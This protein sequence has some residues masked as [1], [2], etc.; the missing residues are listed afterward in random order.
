MDYKKRFLINAFL[1]VFISYLCIHLGKVILIK[2][3][4]GVVPDFSLLKAVVLLFPLFFLFYTAVYRPKFVIFSIFLLGI[5]L[6]WYNNATA[7]SIIDS[8]SW[9]YLRYIKDALKSVPPPPFEPDVYTDP[10]YGPQMI[11]GGFLQTYLHL[12]EMVILYSFSLINFGLLLTSM[13]LFAREK[14][15]EKVG[16]Y[17]LLLSFFAWGTFESGYRSYCLT[18]IWCFFCI[19]IFSFS[20]LFFALFFYVKSLKSHSLKY[21]SG[22]VVCGFLC[23]TNH[24]V[25]GVILL[26]IVFCL[27]VEKVITTRKIHS[28]ALF[29]VFACVTLILT[30]MWPFYDLFY[31]FNRV[32]ELQ[33]LVVGVPPAYFYHPVTLLARSLGVTVVGIFFLWKKR[34]PFVVLLLGGSLLYFFLGFPFYRRFIVPIAFSLHL[35]IALFLSDY[36]HTRHTKLFPAAFVLFL[37]FFAV[38]RPGITGFKYVQGNE[39]FDVSFLD[40][41]IDEKDSKILSDTMTEYLIRTQTD[42]R[43]Q[44]TTRVLPHP[45]IDSFFRLDATKEERI[46]L[47]SENLVNYV[48]IN[49][50]RISYFQDIVESL[51]DISYILY[52]ND[53]CVLLKVTLS[54]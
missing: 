46:T 24:L 48:L 23:C 4:V 47:L 8:D 28:L 37:C 43:V 34:D 20:M 31:T 5:T 53:D 14:Y 16:K 26:G 40:S 11:L 33:E 13:Y 50:H 49:K 21:F 17:F 35:T 10:H 27:S 29:G 36:R 3:W 51:S 38:S 19:D 6:Y 1:I 32:R 9:G 42:F 41:V 7:F 22:S 30:F 18:E 44:S 25:T 2:I 15:N 54:S 52:E 39:A 45:E 12:N